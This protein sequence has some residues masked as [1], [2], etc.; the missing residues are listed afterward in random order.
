MISET[1]ISAYFGYMAGI[2][3]GEGTVRIAKSIPKNGRVHYSP[4][5]QVSMVDKEPL[6][7]FAVL[8]GGNITL[9]KPAKEGYQPVYNWQA[10]NKDRAEKLLT[11]VRPYLLIKKRQAD[12][13]LEFI[14][15]F[16]RYGPRGSNSESEKE[17][18]YD[19]CRILNRSWKNEHQRG[20]VIDILDRRSS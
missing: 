18:Y 1:H 12:L 8:Y 2:I 20:V 10:S 7:L 17:I 3:D 13:L 6:Q 9:Q 4:N 19:L 5:V 16:P 11:D 14:S 15:V